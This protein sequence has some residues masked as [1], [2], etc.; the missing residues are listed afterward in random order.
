MDSLVR[1]S[2]L[3]LDM[4]GV[5]YR[6]NE[7]MPR[8]GEF[9]AFLRGRS[10]PFMLVTNNA[11]RTPEERSAQMAVMGAEVAPSEILVSGQAAAR[12]LRREYPAGTRVHVF[13]MPALVRA[14]EEEGFVPADEDVKIVVASVDLEVTYAKVKRAVDLIRGG[15][16]FIATNLDPNIPSEDGVRPGSGAMVAMLAAASETEPTAIG[17]PEPIMYELAMHQMGARP[18]TTAAV[19]D[20]V[21]TDIVGGK[22][23]SLT[24]ICVLS[25][26]SDRAE[27][28]AAGADFIFDHI[29]GLLD[30][31]RSALSRQAV[32]YRSSASLRRTPDHSTY[33]PIRPLFGF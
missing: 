9:F 15:A 22:R 7:P 6:G 4:D 24:T 3:I 19:G 10:V 21:A 30:A 33:F 8:L 29:G 5:L 23:A 18:E 17:K 11:T 14:M 32:E 12:Y 1:I 2:H 20:R 25:G 16:R 27:A 31:W 28:K 13:G 26:A